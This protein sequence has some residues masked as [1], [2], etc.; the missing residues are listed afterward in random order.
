MCVQQN[1]IANPF[2]VRHL[3]LLLIKY[4]GV[5][6]VLGN[7][8][9]GSSCEDFQLGQMGVLLPLLLRSK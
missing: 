2:G 1:E 9:W 3:H 4:R 5:T 7:V 8:V 6:R